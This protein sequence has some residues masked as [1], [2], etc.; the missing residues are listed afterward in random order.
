MQRCVYRAIL[1]VVMA[2][3]FD[4]YDIPFTGKLDQ[5]T[6]PRLVPAG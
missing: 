3:K 5:G 6:N 4:I 1:G 2:L